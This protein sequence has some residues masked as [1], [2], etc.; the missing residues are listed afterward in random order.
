MK[1]EH[2]HSPL[3]LCGGGGRASQQLLRGGGSRGG[4]G[5]GQFGGFRGWKDGAVRG[6]GQV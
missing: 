2:G 1:R 5:E 4:E 6:L 3:D